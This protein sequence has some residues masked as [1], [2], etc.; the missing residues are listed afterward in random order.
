[1]KRQ[2]RDRGITLGERQ[3]S[4]RFKECPQRAPVAAARGDGLEERRG[5][6]RMKWYATKRGDVVAQ[7]LRDRVPAPNRKIQQAGQPVAFD[8][9]DV[10]RPFV[11]A[12][13][14]E[15][16]RNRHQSGLPELL[17]GRFEQGRHVHDVHEASPGGQHTPQLGHH[18]L[19]VLKRVED[20]KTQDRTQGAG[21]HGQSVRGRDACLCGRGALAQK[22]EGRLGRIGVNHAFAQGHGQ[23]FPELPG[24]GADFDDG[25]VGKGGEAV[26]RFGDNLREQRRVRFPALPQQVQ[27]TEQF[28]VGRR[29][30]GRPGREPLD[31]QAATI[32]YSTVAAPAR[33]AP[34]AEYARLAT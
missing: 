1:M 9:H 28:S 23:P 6:F 18:G 16:I 26:Q 22:A 5:R 15:D 14:A 11:I 17:K 32:T 8:Q 13:I 27:R 24:P 7:R 25:S 34:L 33:E 2:G 4:G 29:R 30:G 19:L 21:I 12:R 20:A 3:P 31:D 10:Q